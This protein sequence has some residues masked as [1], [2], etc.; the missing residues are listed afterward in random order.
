MYKPIPSKLKPP[1]RKADYHQELKAPTRLVRSPAWREASNEKKNASICRKM[2]EKYIYKIGREAVRRSTSI[3]GNRK[4]NADKLIEQ[5]Y[6][7]SK[8]K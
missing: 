8:V 6:G 5:E 7:V 4:G 2:E 3:N 1:L